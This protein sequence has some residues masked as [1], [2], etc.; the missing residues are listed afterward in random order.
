M[1][2][3]LV[4]WAILFAFSAAIHTIAG[5]WWQK[6]TTVVDTTGEAGQVALSLATSGTFSNPWPVLPTGSTAHVAPAYPYLSSR[7]ML[8][9]GS[10]H[11]AW[12]AMNL[13]TIAAF[14][15]QW[16]LLPWIAGVWGLPRAIGYLGAG[17]GAFLPIPGV[18]FKWEAVFV[19]VTFTAVAGLT[20][21]LASGSARDNRWFLTA[22]VWGVGLLLSPVLLLPWLGWS[23]LLVHLSRHTI[24]WR[25]VAVIAF[26]PLLVISPWII[27]NYRVF[28]H[29]FLIRDNLGLTLALSN[30]DCTSAWVK[31]DLRSGCLKSLNPYSNLLVAERVAREGEYQFNIDCLHDGLE[32]IKKNP[33]RFL[34]LTLLRIRYFWFPPVEAEKTDV[35]VLNLCAIWGLTFLSIPGLYLL[36]RRKRE[37]C[38][39]LVTGI[40]LY[41]PVY[42]LAQV[43]LRYRYPILWISVF[44]TAAVLYEMKFPLQRLAHK[45][46]G[47]L[48]AFTG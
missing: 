39:L 28:H 38:A 10:S 15:L 4:L 14:T 44:A 1:L 37:T 17:V 20:G 21:S 16:A 34:A 42:Y 41:S 9:F 7:V 43:E 47:L 40:I 25:N 30:N 6:T 26:V 31:K 12:W 46:T 35:A 19:A 29:V 3:T 23:C 32:W 48:E 24:R 33:T 27:R 11:A 36:Y 5:K 18:S 22:V 8:L 45:L 2:R 13:L